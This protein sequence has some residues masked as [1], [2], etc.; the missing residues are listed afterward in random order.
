LAWTGAAT[1][2]I[3]AQLAAS[4]PI[5]VARRVLN[6]DWFSIASSSR[7]VTA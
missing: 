3:A 6:L 1:R 7:L 5:R 4:V 2:A